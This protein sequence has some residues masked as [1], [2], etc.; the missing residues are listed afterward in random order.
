MVK[1]KKSKGDA[2]V[3]YRD[4]PSGL[5][6]CGL[7]VMYVIPNQCTDVAGYIRPQGWCKLFARKK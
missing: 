3:M 6:R 5:E 1:R 4:R 2:K 7:C